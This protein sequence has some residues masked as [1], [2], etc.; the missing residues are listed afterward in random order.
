[1]IRIALGAL[2]LT[3]CTAQPGA[4]ENAAPPAPTAE[5]SE[6]GAPAG[7]TPP[8]GNSAA[9][10]PIAPGGEASVGPQEGI[11]SGE[12]DAS[13]AQGLVGRQASPEL[14]REAMQ[15]TAARLVRWIRPGQ[16]VTMDYN[17]RRLNIKLD[18]NDRAES[19]DCG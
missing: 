19:F 1:M 15:R 4:T 17:P 18:A 16:A 6:P 13:R 3:A 7:P 5:A 10:G 11:P 14:E 2:L 8:D 12:C 9:P